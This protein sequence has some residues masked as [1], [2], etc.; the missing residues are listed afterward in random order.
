MLR[1]LSNCFV[2]G[3]SVYAGYKGW[4]LYYCIPLA[5]AVGTAGHFMQ[6]RP[7]L[8]ETAPG[9]TFGFLRRVL[10]MMCIFAAIF[11]GAGFGVKWLLR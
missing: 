1:N 7:D 9:G 8:V 3:F 2:F 6:L 4:P 5:A 10:I 11:Y